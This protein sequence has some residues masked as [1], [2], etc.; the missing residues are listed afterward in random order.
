[1]CAGSSAAMLSAINT[2]AG[3]IKVTAVDPALLLSK[4]LKLKD[5]TVA[6]GGNRSEANLVAK[7]EFKTGTG[8]T[9]Y[10]TSGVSPS[11]DLLLSGDVSW[12]GGW[13]ININK[14]GKAQ[15]STA[16]SS[17]LASMISASG[18]YSIEAWVAPANVTQ[19]NAWIV[20][21]SGS[22]TTR[23]VTLGQ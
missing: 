2:F 18:E 20:S 10:D 8:T 19:T 14:G 23:N 11:A 17:K 4:G 21:Y 9:A 6:S 5:G 16:S 12:V 22:D 1:D 3:A 13:G 7:Y 15:A